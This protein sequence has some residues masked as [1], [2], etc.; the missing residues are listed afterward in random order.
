MVNRKVFLDPYS[1]KRISKKKAYKIAEKEGLLIYR[2][3]GTVKELED[4]GYKLP[5]NLVKLV[6]PK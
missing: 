1:E 3:K 6:T 4:N 5:E 2:Y